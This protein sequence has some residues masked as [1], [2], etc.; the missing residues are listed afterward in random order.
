MRVVKHWNRLPREV[1]EAP[2]LETFKPSAVP[3]MVFQQKESLQ[4]PFGIRKRTDLMH[5][6]EPMAF[7]L[8][9][10]KTANE[11]NYTQSKKLWNL[12]TRSSKSLGSEVADE[13]DC[14]I[15]TRVAVALL[16]AEAGAGGLDSCGILCLCQ[17]PDVLASSIDEQV[18]DTA[19]IA[20]VQHC[21]PELCRKDESCPVLRQPSETLIKFVDD[22]KLGRMVDALE[23][24]QGYHSG[25]PLQVQAGDQ[26]A[27]EQL[28]RKGP[29]DMADNNLNTSQQCAVTRDTDH[30]LQQG[31]LQLHRKDHFS[32]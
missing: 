3:L 8:Q 26:L 17:L 29:G 27:K 13:E 4:R 11:T 21:C 30:R 28:C 15:L 24:V 18:S 10:Q 19:D 23:E 7:S 12:K 31:K 2:S 5:L 20:I 9:L 22:I 1:V 16:G 6:F 14:I 32:P 25:K